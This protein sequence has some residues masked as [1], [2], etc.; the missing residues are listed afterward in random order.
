MSEEHE[1]SLEDLQSYTWIETLE[2]VWLPQMQKL[3]PQE[4][5]YGLLDLVTTCKGLIETGAAMQDIL[6]R[7]YKERVENE[8]ITHRIAEDEFSGFLTNK[9]SLLLDKL[10]KDEIFSFFLK[11]LSEIADKDNLSK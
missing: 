3:V 8:N 4:A 11:P 6:M 7:L 5:F 1:L 9:E 10:S 2:N